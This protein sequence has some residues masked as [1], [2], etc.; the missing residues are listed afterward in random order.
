MRHTRS[1]L[2]QSPALVIATIA[3]VFSLAGGVGYAAA[4][5]DSSGISFHNL[6]LNNGWKPSS[7]GGA[8]V[9]AYAVK[10][11]VVYITGALANQSKCSKVI[12]TLPVEA[13]PTHT[14]ILSIFAGGKSPEMTGK[15]VPQ[16]WGA[17]FVSPSG[18]LTINCVPEGPSFYSFD[19]VSFA[20]G[21]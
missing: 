12:A 8:G 5:S 3:L 20:V 2:R 9:R 16:T 11:G 13:R 4:Q 17:L 10:S 6:T 14:Q 21:S 19:G 1:V 15:I 7:A 18:S